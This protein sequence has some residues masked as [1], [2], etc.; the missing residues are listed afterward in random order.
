MSAAVTA[1]AIETMSEWLDTLAADTSSRPAIDK[2]VRAKPA[3]AVDGC[4]DT[5]GTRIDEPATFDGQGRCN[6]LYP[7]HTNPRLSAGAPLADD[8]LKCQ[9]KPVTS[10]DYAVT[11]TAEELGRLRRIFP[12][13]VCDYSKPGVNQVPLAGTYLKLPL[14]SGR[15]A[16]TT[17]SR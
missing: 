2:I 10:S 4:W 8:V 9:V 11:F 13:G 17:A 1:Q 12:R 6:Q 14:G 5:T 7:N 16:P 3:K 15:T